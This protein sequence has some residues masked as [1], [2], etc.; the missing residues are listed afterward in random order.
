MKTI[1]P[2]GAFYIFPDCSFYFGKSFGNRKISNPEDLAL[3]LLEE[4]HVATVGG[5]AFG[6]P[7]CLRFSYAT[8]DENIAKAM[9]RVKEALAKLS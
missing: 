2:E 7:N 9:R 4:G 3:Y 5:T 1:K 6:A 8:S